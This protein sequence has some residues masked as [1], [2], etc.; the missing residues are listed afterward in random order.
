[1][2]QQCLMQDQNGQPA[3]IDTTAGFAYVTIPCK[4]QPARTQLLELG[5][6]LFHN[7]MN[8]RFHTSP[9]STYIYKESDQSVTVNTD[10]TLAH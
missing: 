8:N 4:R 2:E 3:I 7:V 10:Q 5:P 1:M 6:T 9:I